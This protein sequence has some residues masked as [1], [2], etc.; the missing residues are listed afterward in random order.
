MINSAGNYGWPYC[1]GNNQGYRAKLPA[2]TGGGL[3]APAGHPGT[4]SGS[5]PAAGMGGGGYWDCDNPQGIPNE[6][7]YNTGL[8][9]VPAARPTN[10]WYGPQGGCYDF[11]RNANDIPI[12][13]GTGNN[14][15]NTVA[16]PVTYRRCPFAF[17]GGQAPMTG[18][19]YRKP[20]N[21]PAEPAVGEQTAWPAYWDGRWF[22]ADYAGA[23]NLRHALLM[24]PATEFTGGAP[25]AADSL[26]G[27]IP[28]AL[29]GGN[30]MIDLDFGPDG[31]LYVADYGGSNFQITPNTAVRRFAYIGGADTPGPDPQ[32]TPNTNPALT[33]FAFNIGKSGGVS[34]KWSFSDGGTADGASVT[35]TY[36]TAGNGV[37]PSATLT[38]TYADGQQSSKTIDVPVPTAVPSTVTLDVPK[39]LSL[40]IGAPAT[41]GGFVPGVT[42]TYA[43]TTTATV[44]STLPDAA[45]SVTDLSATNAGFLVNGT[46]QLASRLRVRATNTAT[47]FTT[48]AD[49]TNT[50]RT[51]LSYSAP[52]SNDAVSLQFQQP[53]AANEPLKAGPYTKTLTFTLSTTSP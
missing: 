6:S 53:I 4:L 30:R 32:F 39:T 16:E 1:T 7:P 51:L 50:P 15:S 37:A 46:T 19:N 14:A 42:N 9:R 10:I 29:M 49:L 18:G 24:D 23:A 12:Y 27:I 21:A 13:N 22:L 5:D 45:L 34:Y 3:P 8:D 43:A 47:P 31:M 38:V 28:Q 33:T 52:I 11:P 2:T 26:Y 48:F 36:A 44:L 40:K 41:F 17:G 20:A 25:V 35:H